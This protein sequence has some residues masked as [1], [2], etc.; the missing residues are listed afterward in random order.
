VCFSY[1]L[2]S[3]SITQWLV[4][5]PGVSEYLPNEWKQWSSVDGIGRREGPV[6]GWLRFCTGSAAKLYDL[7]VIA[8]SSSCLS[9]VVGVLAGVGAK[10]SNVTWIAIKKKRF[11]WGYFSSCL[12]WF[13]CGPVISLKDRGPRLFPWQELI[14]FLLDKS[15]FSPHKGPSELCFLGESP[16]DATAADSVLSGVPKVKGFFCRRISHSMKAS[17]RTVPLPTLKP[18]F[19]P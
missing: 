15:I 18:D 8:L 14:P 16:G 7:K 10:H 1:K 4:F 11:V 2:Y 3:Q 13:G 12:L 19:P 5:T 17:Q 9:L 6:F